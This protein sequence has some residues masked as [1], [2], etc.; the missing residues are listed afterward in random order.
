MVQRPAMIGM[1]SAFRTVAT[2]KIFS[3]CRNYLFSMSESNAG[4]YGDT[5]LSMVLATAMKMANMFMTRLRWT[6]SWSPTSLLDS[7]R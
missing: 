5:T 4:R 3:D 6:A 1:L 7:G 2:Q